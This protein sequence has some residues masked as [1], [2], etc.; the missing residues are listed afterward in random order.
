[1]TWGEESFEL[2]GLSAEGGD[3]LDERGGGEA[4]FLAGHDENGFDAGDPSVGQGDAEL[5]V[6]VGEVAEAPEDGG[7]LAF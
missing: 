2:L 4:E 7:G 5:V 1:M 3:L 6:E